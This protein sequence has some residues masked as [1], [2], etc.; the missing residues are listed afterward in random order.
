MAN[1][2]II[3]GDG[4]EYGPVTDADVRQH[5][6]EIVSQLGPYQY[7]VSR[8][9]F[10]DEPTARFALVLLE[11]GEPLGNV[12]ARTQAT[13]AQTRWFSFKSPAT[14]AHTQELPLPLAQVIPTMKVGDITRVP[15]RLGDRFVIACLDDRRD[16][17]IPSF[18]DAK[19]AMRKAME[20][21]KGD[22][23]FAALIAQLAQKA[24]IR[25]SQIMQDGNVRS[26]SK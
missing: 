22:D 2:L 11:N 4:K 7:Q 18:A 26:A 12:A 13:D 14:E 24:V 1:Y 9:S 17:V 16:T 15:V 20:E 19:A 21:K 5:Y 10:A 23:A 3:G 6:D 25:Q 8:M